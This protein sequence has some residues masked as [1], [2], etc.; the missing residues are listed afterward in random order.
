MSDGEDAAA[1][2]SSPESPEDASSVG[3]D[4]DNKWLTRSSRPTPGA[5]PWERAGFAPRQESDDS[6]ASKP[7]AP[8]V[9]VGSHT[10]GVTV[11]DL[12]AKVTGTARDDGRDPKPAE[13]R[14]RRRSTA[15]EADTEIIQVVPAHAS[16]LPVLSEAGSGL[17]VP[18]RVG[19]TPEPVKAP[20]SHR[21]RR[22]AM[23]VGRLAGDEEPQ[24]QQGG[25]AGPQLARHR[26][27]RRAIR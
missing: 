12:I 24:S 19:P 9:A 7:E 11:A 2:R 18:E 23:V 26:R 13:P 6:D 22:S 25:G 5:A 1:G 14:R 15:H 16:E 20:A 17:A 10:D 4:S 8:P 21:G 3:A 27:P